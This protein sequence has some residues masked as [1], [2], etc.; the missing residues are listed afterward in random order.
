MSPSLAVVPPTDPDRS[1][2]APAAEAIRD[3]R[4]GAFRP[5]FPLAGVVGDN[6]TARR[7][8][9]PL[10][11][12]PLTGSFSYPV[13]LGKFADSG[14][15][16]YPASELADE[17][18]LQGYNAGGAPGSLRD[19]FDEVSYLDYTI[20]GTVRGWATVSLNQSD[21]LGS[22]GCNG[23]CSSTTNS[24]A[25]FAK[26]LIE[27]NDAAI[28]FSQYDNDGPDGTP[29]SGDDDGVV[30]LLVLVHAAE[31]GECGGSEIWSHLDNYSRTFG[32]SFQTGDAAS[33]GGNILI[34][35]Y[36]VVP[37][38]DCDGTTRV[39]IGVFA[40]LFGLHLGW[41]PLW[42]RDGSSRGAGAWEL[43][44]H[45]LWGGDG[46]SPQRPVH[47]S[48]Y[49]KALAGWIDPSVVQGDEIGTF[50]AAIEDEPF[51]REFRRAP[52]CSHEE[53][54]L[55]EAR[56]K[57]KFDLNLPGEGLL[58][59]HADDLT[60][61]SDDEARPR[62]HLLPAD[63]EYGLNNDQDDGDD[64]DPWPGSLFESLWTDTTDPSSKR[65]GGRPSGASM[66][67]VSPP[68]D[69]MQAD[70]SQETGPIPHVLNV[71]PDD[72]SPGNGDA[73]GVIDPF[74]TVR[75]DV[76]LSNEGQAVATAVSGTLALDPPI[77]GVS[78]VQD[79]ADWPDLD[80][81][82]VGATG[83]FDISLDAS[84]ACETQ[85]D[86]RLDLSTGQGPFTRTFSERVGS[87]F[88]GAATELTASS[89]TAGEPRSSRD[90]TGFAIVYP[91][92]VSG[93][94]VVRMTRLDADGTPLGTT[95]V[96]SPL[97]GNGSDPDVDWNGTEYGVVWADDRDGNREIYFAR[98]DAA[99]TRIG[100][101]VRLTSDAADSRAPRIEW[102]PT[103]KRWSIVFEDERFGDPD[104]LYVR[105]N[106]AG[107]KVGGETT[108]AVGAGRQQ[109]PDLAFS[110]NRYG[111]VWQ[112]DASGEWTIRF[113][114]MLTDGLTGSTPI[115]LETAPGDSLQP[116]IIWH[117]GTAF[118][119]TAYVDFAAIGRSSLKVARINELGSSLQPI[120]TITTEPIRVDSPDIDNDG[121]LYFISWVDHRDGARSI[122][123]SRTDDQLNVEINGVVADE[124]AP[125]ARFAPLTVSGNRMIVTWSE[126]KA[127][128]PGFDA[129]ARVSYGFFDCGRDE[130]GDGIL[131]QNDNCPDVPNVDQL[132]SDEDGWGDACDCAVNDPTINPGEPEIVCDTIDNDCSATTPDTPDQDND[133]WDVCD[134]TDPI[135]PDGK[136]VDCD[137]TRDDI[138][139]GAI[140]ACDSADNDCDGTIDGETGPRYVDLTGSDAGNF[141]NDP[142]S[143][144]ATITHAAF[145]ACP[146]ETV[147]VAE[148]SYVED[149]VIESPVV[150]DASGIAANT[151]VT[152]SGSTDIVTI[153]SDD[154]TWD[155]IEVRNTAGHA[156]VRIGDA[157]HP[158]VRNI[159]VQGTVISDC[160]I[161]VVIDSIGPSPGGDGDNVRILS[162]VIEN[163]RADGSTNGG[164]G[165][166]L[167]G[168]NGGATIVGGR[169][170]FND[171][172]GVRI[173]APP[174]GATNESISIVGV[175]LHDNGLDSLADSF[176][177]VEV[178][179]GSNIHLEGNRI[180]NHIGPGA[181]DDGHAI[182][183]D[184][185][186][187]GSFFCNRIEDNDGGLE[188]T[189][190]TS[191]VA[192][193]H[194]RFTGQA[195]TAVSVGPDSG[196]GT[197]INENVFSG[198]GTGLDHQGP[199]TL[200]A[201]HNWW[202][203]ADGPGPVGS[204]DTV[205]GDVDTSN[206]I[207]RSEAPV[208]V[209]RP[210]LSGWSGTTASCQP[211]IQNGIDQAVAGDL[212]LIGEGI[213]Q[214]K[215]T[216]DKSIDLEGISGGSGCSPTEINGLQ[217]G[218]SHTPAVIVSDVA[219]VSM[220][221]LTIRSTA[222]GQACGTST[223]EEIGLDLRNADSSTFSDLCFKEN[224]VSEIRV[225]GD[226]DDN[227]FSRLTIDG[228]IRRG[229]GTDECGHRSREAVLV[230]GGPACEGGPGAIADNNV[231]TDL[232]INYV[233]R[234]FS[235]QL[236]DGTQ[237]IDSTLTSSPAP[238]WDGG[239][240]ALGVEIEAADNTT[241]LRNTIGSTEE[242][243]GIRVHGKRAGSCLTE[244]TDSAGTLIDDNL[245]RRASQRGV[246]LGRDAGDPGAPVDTELRCNRIRFNEIGVLTQH[247]G[248]TTS[249]QNRLSLND[250]TS[251]TTGVQNTATNTLPAQ[252]NWWGDASGPSGGG[253]GSG[254]SVVG[255]VSF[256]NWLTTSARDDGD[257]DGYTEC[258]GDC[259]DEDNALSPGA[260]ELCDEID[261]DCDGSID[262]DLTLNTYYRDSDGDGFGDVSDFVEDCA[263]TP[264]TGYVA[265]ADDCDDTN[266]QINPNAA[267]IACDN[268][269]Q[270]CSGFGNEAPDADGDGYDQCAP[271][272]P[273]DGDGLPA[274]CNES[275]DQINPGAVEIVCDNVDQDCSGF[276][277]ESPDQDNDNFDVCDPTDPYDADGLQADCNDADSEINP[278]GVEVCSDSADNDCNG[279]A[280][281]DDAACGGLLVSALR[282]EAGSKTSLAWD[283]ATTAN[284]YALYRGDIAREG[285]RGYDHLCEASE[286]AGT[287]A[288]DTDRPALGEAFYYL[289]TALAI[290]EPAGTFDAGS[291][292]SASNGD[293]RAD[294]STVTCGPRVYVD[295]DAIG[296]GTGMS[297]ADA[298]TTVS[299]ALGHRTARDRSLEVWAKG[300]LFDPGVNLT[301][302]NRPGARFLGGF[303]GTETA[304]WQRDPSAFPTTWQGSGSSHLLRSTHA[305]VVFDGMSLE[306]A[307]TAVRATSDGDLVQLVDVSVSQISQ[308]AVDQTADGAG[309]G[310]IVVLSSDVDASGQ[311][312]VRA[313]THLGTL[314]GRL[315]SHTFAGGSD[316]VIR[317]EARPT[318]AD[319]DVQVELFGNRV[320]GGL[321]GLV[322]GTHVDDV[323]RTARHNAFVASNLIAGTSGDAVRVESS[324][325]FAASADAAAA[326]AEP[327]LVGNTISDAAGAGIVAQVTRSDSTGDPSVHQVRS[328]PQVWNSLL[329]FHSS[330]AIE[331]SA[332]D[333][334]LGLVAAPIV[335]GNMVFGNGG[336]Y[337][338][339]GSTPLASVA[340]LNGLAEARDNVSDDPRYLN[341]GANDYQ[342]RSSSPAIDLGL[343]DAPQSWTEALGEG[344]RERDGNADGLAVADLGAYEAPEPSPN[345]ADIEL[346]KIDDVDP[347][348]AGGQVVYTIRAENRG[349]AEAANVVVTD[350]LPPELTFVSTSGCAEDPNGV[351][352]C[353]LGSIPAGSFAEYTLTANLASDVAH[354]AVLVNTADATTTTP[355][356]DALNNA[357]SE[358][359]SVANAA[360]AATKGSLDVNGGNLE[361]G[362]EIEY[363]VSVDNVGGKDA[364]GVS[365]SDTIPLNTT[366]VAGSA[367]ASQGTVTEGNPLTW[368][369]GTL[370]TGGG[371]AT[372]T[373]R[374]TVD[375][376]VADGTDVENQA[377]FSYAERPA[378]LVLT[379]STDPDD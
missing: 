306:A 288:E 132:D 196:S 35:D 98:V 318:G 195:N 304:S 18:F 71:M 161:G 48:V 275:N 314:S 17:L 39:S 298:Y 180:Y 310:E 264:P 88:T 329:T 41:P 214:Q 251:N 15:D 166:L 135:N 145:M 317:L 272:D 342:L 373:F 303:A 227:T 284:A 7:T 236:A 146:N 58:I 61:T 59:W 315:R 25:G 173:E 53:Y 209:R 4:A 224:G 202:G 352:T 6:V 119:A 277:N 218:G 23:L 200:D 164:T 137:D 87:W 56:L 162:S 363:T 85:L 136:G 2:P 262:E 11:L 192:V 253:P 351:P 131:T 256:A 307:T 175:Q 123:M 212:V 305:D 217:S 79:S 26:E 299:A 124:S 372:L 82:G 265:N 205:S 24:A 263:G 67:D 155:G 31:G 308:Y 234:G 45:G 331:E 158:G 197:L 140:E 12:T 30:D 355:E 290:D 57:R 153:L 37:A 349:L 184:G 42:D 313:V 250:I 62:L 40:H 178:H 148:G 68:A 280:D 287:A 144:C 335:A 339:E 5:L 230:D 183:W 186:D 340:E 199:A 99:G 301:R 20:D 159:R 333:P 65:H 43:M 267:E 216:V 63:A 324:G 34:E 201:R 21:Y 129:F 185:V 107:N 346:S 223:G 44:A 122:R 115:D 225:Y 73:D 244:K 106:S 154:V 165:I 174:E 93:F 361:P 365:M 360:L 1:I 127:A 207:D 231:F 189:G 194:N 16:P 120:K 95:D 359:T 128:S 54:F 371:S 296:E 370:A 46:N 374:V 350:T 19:Y 334:A 286:L 118:F 354:D 151:R 60:E 188:F 78:V 29:N 13:L 84:V 322:L 102:T 270:D 22:A 3:D 366:L 300:T 163:H 70:L 121:T 293:W 238:A 326:L 92:R 233:T 289:A 9:G 276:G 358:Q 72:D 221:Y 316:A 111:I 252:R 142:G 291:F 327:V 191:N 49:C 362:D 113:R 139:P 143:P 91:E 376:G 117:S 32:S 259:D 112:D 110:G 278:N 248:P 94:D 375:A 311:G 204:G 126:Q 156:C 309:G 320:D 69:P 243:D 190:G 237:I 157:A 379:D 332:D 83:A 226:S 337:L 268:V 210:T 356:S 321:H 47:P 294:S 97:T 8:A 257:S 96:S 295:P 64:A 281:G 133:T 344:T 52:S 292:G 345:E 240:V 255:A 219:G 323:A 273:F 312:A 222:R 36:I 168:G 266:D 167:T 254:D 66:T 285:F 378:D 357:A 28:D 239:T 297:W 347:A 114:S 215:I 242:T 38:Y 258:Q 172:A 177:A 149:V 181:G 187:G 328:A 246:L 193:L 261:N 330:N 81:C 169:V 27:L 343:L 369:V 269:D 220:R 213:Y 77:S 75:L 319:A 274:D 90:D 271:S 198:N 247:V 249:P 235:I 76:E 141:C 150:V 203:A 211:T 260:A 336:V 232:E 138:F 302:S 103:D 147:N 104:V 348:L 206:F 74:E 55:L 51:A 80:A 241:I 89:E 182:I 130:D 341:R 229:D 160:T 368:D 377:E 125:Y 283:P 134:V 108:I 86:F 245:I 176:A 50:I 279:Q 152:G 171:G 179:S 33:G 364:T 109:S 282:F 100:T 353:T 367:S 105:V 10:V 338:D 228:M 208:L 101:E 116:E 325:T 170:R 14:A